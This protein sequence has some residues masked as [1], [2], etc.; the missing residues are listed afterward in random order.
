MMIVG[1]TK[2]KE[3]MTMASQSFDLL[4]CSNKIVENDAHVNTRPSRDTIAIERKLNSIEHRDLVTKTKS[5]LI[6][7]GW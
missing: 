7:C 3:A 1:M 2:R 6:E 4:W 5:S